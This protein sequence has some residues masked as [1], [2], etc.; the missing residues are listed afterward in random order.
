MKRFFALL[1]GT[2]GL[3]TATVSSSA[4]IA[5]VYDALLEKIVNINTDSRN[6][7]GLDAVRALLL[8]RFEALGFKATSYELADGHR[9]VSFEYPD[10]QPNILMIGHLDTVFPA[11]GNFLRLRREGERFVGPGV[12]DMKGGVVLM[13]NALEELRREGVLPQVRVV[14]ND[15]EEIGSPHSKATLRDLAKGAK[16]GLVFE[17]GLEDGAL[18]KGQAGVRWLKLMV[19]GKAAHAGLEPQNGINACVEL[20][21]KLIKMSEL[22]RSDSGLYVNPGVIEG[23]TKPNVV[24]E[25]ASSTIDVRFQNETDLKHLEQGLE[26]IRGSST[27]YNTRLNAGTTAEI[28]QIAELPLLSEERTHEL[29]KTAQ[30]I[31]ITLGQNVSARTVGY[32]SDGN[33]LANSGIELLVGLGPYGGGMHTDQEYLD[34]HSYVQRLSLVKTLLLNLSKKIKSN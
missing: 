28:K 7:A 24:C 17:P 22:S 3:C 25:K 29:V 8:P 31:A 26:R 4:N 20:A 34:I 6:R 2:I 18:V 16:Y 33:N 14:L 5:P 19:H 11:T 21:Y 10:S 32:G 30:E 15:D 23:G 12:I 9:L 13:L 1:L 27:L